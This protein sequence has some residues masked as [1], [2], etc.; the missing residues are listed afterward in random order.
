MRIQIENLRKHFGSTLVL[1]DIDLDIRER[2]FLG[3]LGPSG[4]ARRRCCAS[5]P[6]SNSPTRGG[7]CSTAP[8]PAPC[9]SSGA[10]SAWCFSIT[11]CSAT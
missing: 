10:R 5:L 11:P 4:S 2:E 6:A 7:F 3:L 1:D 8:M 9:P